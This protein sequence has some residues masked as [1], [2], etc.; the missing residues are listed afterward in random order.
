MEIMREVLSL[1]VDNVI[2]SQS[3]ISHKEPGTIHESHTH[4]NSYYSGVYYFEEDDEPI[5]PITFQKNHV[6]GNFNTIY[7]AVDTN[8]SADKPFAWDFY[9]LTPSPSTLIFFPSW[10]PHK[11]EVNKSNKTRKCLAFNILP[12]RLGTAIKL[13]E[14]II[15]E[16]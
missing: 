16:R 11:V 15:H 2:I 5:E 7:V 1:D 3:W 9:K 14:L 4:G 13:N 8:R 6:P 10:L 12:K